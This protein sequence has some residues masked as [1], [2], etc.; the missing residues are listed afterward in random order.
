MRRLTFAIALTLCASPALAQHSQVSPDV[1]VKLLNAQN[2]QPAAGTKAVTAEALVA[3]LAT[4]D[5]TDAAVRKRIADG[6][7]GSGYDIWTNQVLPNRCATFPSSYAV[8]SPAVAG[9]PSAGSWSNIA[10]VSNYAQHVDN[11]S[12]GVSA[13]ITYNAFSL[14]GSHSDASSNQF[15]SYSSYIDVNKGVVGDSAM[16]LK[17]AGAA[18]EIAPSDF[19]K[20]ALRNPT[21]G[22]FTRVCG[23][24]YVSKVEFGERIS[25]T[26]DYVVAFNSSTKSNSSSVSVG[27]AGILG[28]SVSGGSAASS[29]SQNAAISYHVRGGPPQDP[30]PDHWLTAIRTYGS[31]GKFTQSN[32][33]VFVEVTPYSTM[34]DPAFN[35]FKDPSELAEGAITT[36]RTEY[37]LYLQQLTDTLAAQSNSQIFNTPTPDYKTRIKNLSDYLDAA[38]AVYHE[39]QKAITP[40]LAQT[41][42]NHAKAVKVPEF[43]DPLTLK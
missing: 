33:V 36:L 35:S 37:T 41:C 27:V 24:A 20:R 11:Q 10:Y 9:V 38:G 43:V 21:P 5:V 26:M 12:F 16:L 3:P 4:V 42:V 14:G 23:Q 22:S 13:T 34:I 18:S 39:C 6:L 1:L 25:G 32:E 28:G 15:S 40:A 31:D 7:L 8:F 30:D 19:A 2:A 29:L 17:P